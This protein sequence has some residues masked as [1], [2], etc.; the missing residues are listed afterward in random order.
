MPLQPSTTEDL[1]FNFTRT[2]LPLQL[3]F[4]ITIH[5]SQGQTLAYVGLVL[6]PP[7]FAHGQLYVALSRVTNHNSLHLVVP[8]TQ[9]ARQEGTINNIVY[10]E[11]LLAPR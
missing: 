3:A 8:E 4:A 1:P 5:K 11:V 2:Q 10:R 6:D 9:E 7:V